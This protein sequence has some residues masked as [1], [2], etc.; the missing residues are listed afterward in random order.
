MLGPHDSV[1]ADGSYIWI[2]N[3]A[4]MFTMQ[5]CRRNGS[6]AYV[7]TIKLICRSFQ[8][9]LFSFQGDGLK[10]LILN[11]REKGSLT[12]PEVGK[13]YPKWFGI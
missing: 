9:S 7:L 3:C 11:Q 8:D 2:D 12:C 1:L 13:Q 6:S 4:E 5:F 10:E